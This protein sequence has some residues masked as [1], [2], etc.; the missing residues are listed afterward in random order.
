MY[1]ERQTAKVIKEN[2][3]LKAVMSNTKIVREANGSN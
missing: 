1:D 3:K 2:K